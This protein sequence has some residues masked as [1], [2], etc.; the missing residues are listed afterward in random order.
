M[1]LEKKVGSGFHLGKFKIGEVLLALSPVPHA[2]A[3]E[4]KL[5]RVKFK[6]LFRVGAEK[7]RIFDKQNWSIL[8]KSGMVLEKLVGENKSD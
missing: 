3:M 1:F 6:R 2:G 5:F 4:D 7:K 8:F